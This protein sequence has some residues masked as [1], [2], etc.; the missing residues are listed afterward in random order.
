MDCGTIP[1]AGCACS[2]PFIKRIFNRKKQMDNDMMQTYRNRVHYMKTKKAHRR[3]L[4]TMNQ[5]RRKTDFL[6][7]RYE[8]SS[9]VLRRGTL[10]PLK[11]PLSVRDT[12]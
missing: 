9:N 4:Y 7:N 1:I 12:K 3:R 6:F 5:R 11:V 2:L 8:M 10:P